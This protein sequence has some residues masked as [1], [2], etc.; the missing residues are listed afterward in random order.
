MISIDLNEAGLTFRIRQN[1][2]TTIKDLM[3]RGILRRNSNP[4]IGINALKDIN[5]H[6]GEGERIG[7]MGH[8]GAGKSTLLKVL[9]EAKSTPIAFARKMNAASRE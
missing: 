3:L 1:G 6:I 8:N 5:L 2:R 9:A 4:W 7:L